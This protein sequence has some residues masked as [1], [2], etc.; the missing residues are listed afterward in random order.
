M[1]TRFTLPPFYPR[2]VRLSILHRSTRS[3]QKHAQCTGGGGGI[4]RRCGTKLSQSFP[5]SLAVKPRTP[6]RVPACLP[7]SSVFPEASSLF[8]Q[9]VALCEQPHNSAATLIGAEAFLWQ[10]NGISFLEL[11]P[12]TAHTETYIKPHRYSQRGGE[13]ESNLKATHRR[14]EGLFVPLSVPPPALLC[15]AP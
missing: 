7:S 12:A 14:D 6:V 5:L 13:I 11:P 15:A 9:A 8:W 3:A 10:G 1:Y 4:R 2:V